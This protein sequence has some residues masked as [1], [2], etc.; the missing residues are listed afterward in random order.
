MGAAENHTTDPTVEADL[1]AVLDHIITGKPLD[2]ELAR[3]VRERSERATEELRR[4][5]GTR[6]I[7]VE[8]VREARDEE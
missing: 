8:L 5:Y 6:E 4:Q 7:A 1:Q 2:P 3:R